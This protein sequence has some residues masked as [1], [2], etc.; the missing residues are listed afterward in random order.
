[1]THNLRDFRP[2][3]GLGETIVTPREIV[4]RLMTRHGSR[5]VG[6]DENAATL[7]SSTIPRPGIQWLVRDAQRGK[8][9]ILVAETLG[10]G[11]R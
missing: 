5:V 3:L 7:G 2:V 9:K 8:F 6:S 1:M 10:C 4:R 11:P